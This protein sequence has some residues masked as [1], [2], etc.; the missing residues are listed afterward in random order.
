M[1]PATA[2]EIA[3][4]S[5]P[6]ATEHLRQLRDRLWNRLRAALADRV[7]ING[8]PTERLPNTLNVSFVGHIGSDYTNAP[9][10][11]GHDRTIFRMSHSGFNPDYPRVSVVTMHYLVGTADGIEHTTDGHYMS[12]WNDNELLDAFDAAGCTA[13]F[14][15][16]GFGNG[17]YVAVKR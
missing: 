16:P 5:L 7:V 15:L 4:R 3:N 9:A 17:V 6:A 8:H 13:K 11:D 14:Y 10:A 12:M 2:C 1:R